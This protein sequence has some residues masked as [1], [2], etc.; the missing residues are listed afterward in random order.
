MTIKAV[1]LKESKKPTYEIH[2]R[3]LA[4]ENAKV[5]KMSFPV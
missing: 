5:Y 3:E 2:I 4:N 1:K